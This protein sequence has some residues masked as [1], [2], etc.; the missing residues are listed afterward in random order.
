M[1][2]R[3][4]AQEIAEVSGF[5]RWQEASRYWQQY[6][7]VPDSIYNYTGSK[8]DYTD[9]YATRGNWINWLAGG[10]AVYPDGE[11]L[12]IPVELALAFHTDAGTTPWNEIIG[13]LVIYTSWDDEKN[14][15]YPTGATRQL[16][17]D[18]A[19]YLQTQ[20]VNDVRA[21]YAP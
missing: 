17:R 19:D 21:L 13:T 20:L 6:S 11:G 15:T 5:P 3:E 12:G 4:K 18:F 14:K 1:L 10:S 8:N 7:G 2:P 9:D 16:A